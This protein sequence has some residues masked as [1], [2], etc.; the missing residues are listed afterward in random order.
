[1]ISS[2]VCFRPKCITVPTV[3]HTVRSETVLRV[4][5]CTCVPTFKIT[6]TLSVFSPELLVDP[7]LFRRSLDLAVQ[8]VRQD[9]R[10]GRESEDTKS[11]QSELMVSPTSHSAAAQHRSFLSPR[12]PTLD[13]SNSLS[14]AYHLTENDYSCE[15]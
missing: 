15:C 7:D 2:G 3:V 4:G 9:G 13:L 10:S 6:K 8:R 5:I 1:M 14:Q 11:N 12:T